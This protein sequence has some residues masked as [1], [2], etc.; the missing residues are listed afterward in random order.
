[1]DIGADDNDRIS[2]GEKEFTIVLTPGHTAGCASLI[3]ENMVFT[4]DT[5]LIRKTGR[6][7]FQ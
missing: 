3:I 7:D 4:G 2:L 5:L 1:M 6:T